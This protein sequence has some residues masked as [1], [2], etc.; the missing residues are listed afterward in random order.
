MDSEERKKIRQYSLTNSDLRRLYMEHLN[1][2]RKI[3][4]LETSAFLTAE[5]QML[6]QTLKKRKLVGKEAMVK[7]VERLSGTA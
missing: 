7:M 5:E 6:K 4:S 2:E 1:F 3:A